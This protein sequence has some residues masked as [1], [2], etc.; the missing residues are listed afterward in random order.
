[1]SDVESLKKEI[2]AIKTRNMRVEKDKT[3]E[4]SLTRRVAISAITYVLISIFLTIIG[5]EKPFLS[6]IIP[7]VAFLISTATLNILKNRWL[8]NQK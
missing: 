1:M 5:I 7:A 8:K 3:W 4:T 6:S 2:D